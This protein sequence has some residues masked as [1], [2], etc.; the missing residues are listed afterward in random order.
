MRTMFFM[1]RMLGMVVIMVG[2]MLAVFIFLDIMRSGPHARGYLIG[3]DLWRDVTDF[4]GM[5]F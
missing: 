5:L 4:F 3:S 2:V 1:S